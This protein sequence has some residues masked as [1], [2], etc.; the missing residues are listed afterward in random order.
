MSMSYRSAPMRLLFKLIIWPLECMLLFGLLGCLRL[1]P[2]RIASSMMGAIFRLIGPVTGWHRRSVRHLSLAFP[3]MDMPHRHRIART[4]WDNLGRN[5]GEYM[6]LDRMLA[7]GRI[8]FDGTDHLNRD[9][10]GIIIGAH[11]ANWEA[12]SMLGRAENVPIGLIYR[13]LNNPYANLAFARRPAIS[14]ADSYQKGRE[15]SLGMLRT[16]RKNG[17]MLM[18][19]DQQ[20]REGISIPFFGHPAKTAISHIRIA[21]KQDKPIYLARVTRAKDASIKVSISPALSVDNTADIDIETHRIATDINAEIE[22]W[23]TKCPEQW[24]WPHRRWGKDI[25][26]R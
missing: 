25:L 8:T 15:A 20:L 11:L 22:R 9:K 14:G 13:P 19:V 18:L 5:V 26:G 4:M 21:L 12:L 24:L 10:G 2:P 16:L 1:L 17:F 7:S 6:H 3:D 23:I